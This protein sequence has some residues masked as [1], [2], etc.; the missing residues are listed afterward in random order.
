MTIYIAYLI[1]SYVDHGRLKI[2]KES[3][4][5]KEHKEAE[6]YFVSDFGSDRI[7]DYESIRKKMLEQKE[8][9]DLGKHY[10]QATMMTMSME[11]I[12]KMFNRIVFVKS[13]TMPKAKNRKWKK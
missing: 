5:F 8:N 4:S 12:P 6:N 10:N 1:Q 11:K 13:L 3:K 9:F 7:D 2:Y